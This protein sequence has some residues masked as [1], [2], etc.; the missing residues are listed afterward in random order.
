[1]NVHI[2][3]NASKVPN[4]ESP[5]SHP[6]QVPPSKDPFDRGI[7][8]AQICSTF[9]L[10]DG[11]TCKSMTIAAAKQTG[12]G[13]TDSKQDSSHSRTT[14][15]TDLAAQGTMY[16]SRRG[17]RKH[18]VRAAY[19][20]RTARQRGRGHQRLSHRISRD[21]AELGAGSNDEDLAVL[22]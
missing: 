15:N 13:H 12:Q 2:S 7:V 16:L 4:A 19:I 8:S 18:T 3:A 9:G 10:T 22:V 17:N 20:H 1:M 6:R 14:S 21:V 5:A 11:E